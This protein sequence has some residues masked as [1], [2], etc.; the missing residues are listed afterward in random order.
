MSLKLYYQ[1]CIVPFCENN[2]KHAPD[3]LFIPVPRQPEIR[4]QWLERATRDWK[5]LSFKTTMYFCE[6]H[7]DLP[8][9]MNNYME[10]HIMGSVSQVRL[11]PG[12]L[13]NKFDC[14]PGRRKRTCH[15]SEQLDILKKQ[16]KI[17]IEECLK[18]S[19]R[20]KS[21]HTNGTNSAPEDTSVKT[22]VSPKEYNYKLQ[23]QTFR[24]PDKPAGAHEYSSKVI[25]ANIKRVVQKSSSISSSHKSGST[26]PCKVEAPK[27]LKPSSTSVSR[28]SKKILKK[29]ERSNENIQTI[30]HREVSPSKTRKYK[31]PSVSQMKSEDTENIKDNNENPYIPAS[32]SILNDIAS[33]FDQVIDKLTGHKKHSDSVDLVPSIKI[34]DD[35]KRLEKYVKTVGKRVHEYSLE[36]SV[37]SSVLDHKCLSSQEDEHQRLTIEIAKLCSE[38][39][40]LENRL[41]NPIT[42]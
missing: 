40:Y 18:E 28:V 23:L 4:K 41:I 3:K 32:S 36:V 21:G 27:K 35:I 6:D 7:F 12:C 1:Y 9:D 19:D 26:S 11:K 24:T 29:K 42:K 22:P 20:N 2:T 13:P 15:N 25:S 17:I 39:A 38:L 33:T 31:R 37:R 34:A 5:R 10:Y 8:N 16:R 14:Q 30:I